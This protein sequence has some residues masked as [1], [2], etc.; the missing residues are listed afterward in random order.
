MT[1]AMYPVNWLF[2]VPSTAYVV[3]ICANLLIGL[4]CTLSTFI[5]ELFTD[6]SV[7]I[8][9]PPYS[10]PPV[11]RPPVDRSRFLRCATSTHLFGWCV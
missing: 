7:K 8:A 6:K 1:P 4:T 9:L 2:D 11:D 5:L 3:L 10:R